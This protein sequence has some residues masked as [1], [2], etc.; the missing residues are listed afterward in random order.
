[1]LTGLIVM[2][3][4]IRGGSL[5]KGSWSRSG[6][7]WTGTMSESVGFERQVLGFRADDCIG[8]YRVYG[9]RTLKNSHRLYLVLV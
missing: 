2:K 5:G 4:G 3:G 9:D 6:G 8:F 7:F 1:M